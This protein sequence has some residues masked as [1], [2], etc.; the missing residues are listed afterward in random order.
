MWGGQIIDA[1][2]LNASGVATM[3]R[4]LQNANSY[5]LTAVYA[6]DANNA[7]S[8]SAV[9]NQVIQQA[10]SSATLSS[11]AN[12]S[13]LGQE[14]TFTAKI[15]SPTVIASGPVTFMAGTTELGSAQLKGGRAEF[16]TSTL[17][18]GT[19]TVTATYSGDSNI[20]QSSASVTQT[21]Q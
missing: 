1:A 21:V 14:V 5:A 6:G 11:S 20:A 16:T 18:A 4:S 17:A 8:T 15:T 7:S 13:T 10:T 9:L 12:P 3:T 2:T 19:T